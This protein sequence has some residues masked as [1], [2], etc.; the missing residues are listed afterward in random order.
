MLCSYGDSGARLKVVT[1]PG[2]VSTQKKE[3]TRR[4]HQYPSML[5]LRTDTIP[6]L[7]QMLLVPVS[8]RKWGL[9]HVENKR[10]ARYW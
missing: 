7:E 8:S 10:R 2:H 1:P 6:L 4:S 9:P 5:G 3:E